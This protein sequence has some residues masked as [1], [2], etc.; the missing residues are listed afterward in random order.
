MGRPAG[1]GAV[2]GAVRRYVPGTG[3][4]RG[5]VVEFHGLTLCLDFVRDVLI[6]S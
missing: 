2:G 5:G 3:G 4:P 1:Q 6:F